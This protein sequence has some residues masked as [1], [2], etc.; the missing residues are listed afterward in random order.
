MPRAAKPRAPKLH[1]SSP[2]GNHP[3]LLPC[4]QEAVDL[5]QLWRGTAGLQETNKM[6]THRYQDAT[7]GAS[8][9]NWHS[10]LPQGVLLAEDV[11]GQ[12]LFWPLKAERTSNAPMTE[13]GSSQMSQLH[14]G[15]SAPWGCT[16][17]LQVSALRW[18][19]GVFTPSAQH[20]TRQR[21][22]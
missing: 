16:T 11:A 21:T 10:Q 3:P 7:E 15:A 20:L 14:C 1:P 5:P 2:K 22:W 4:Q 18:E 8:C 12:H 6:K 17:S 9:K 13:Q 19:L